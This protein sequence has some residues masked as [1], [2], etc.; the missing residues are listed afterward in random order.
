MNRIKFIQAV[1]LVPLLIGTFGIGW[2]FIKRI[3]LPYNSEGRYFDE[4]S[5]VVY[6]QQAVVVY[7]LLSIIV[8]AIIVGVVYRLSR[9]KNSN[10]TCI[11]AG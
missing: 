10:S 1:I 9:P 4:G 7:G 8:L 11:E 3:R 2:V 6:H 5:G